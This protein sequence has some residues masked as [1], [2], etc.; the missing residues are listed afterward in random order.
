MTELRVVMLCFSCFTNN[1]NVL[2][3]VYMKTLTIWVLFEWGIVQIMGGLE[4]TN[5][6]LNLYDKLKSIIYL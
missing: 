3:F 6:Y 2:K 4:I 1:F 5:T